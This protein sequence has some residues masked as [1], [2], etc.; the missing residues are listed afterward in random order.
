MNF[1]CKEVQGEQ[2]VQLARTGFGPQ[3][4]FRKNNAPVEC[5]RQ[6]ELATASAFVSLDAVPKINDQNILKELRGK[7][8]DL[9]DSSCEGAEIDLLIGADVMGRLLTGN[10]VTLHS[11]LAAVE[12]KLVLD[13]IWKTKI[14]WK[15]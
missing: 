8:I 1:L 9:T 2:R 3:H 13:G 6:R 5:I 10:V 11:G 4:N 14:L 7:N 12:S 15:G